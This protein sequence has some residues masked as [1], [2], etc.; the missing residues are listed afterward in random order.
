V[1]RTF[2]LEKLFTHELCAL[3]QEPR[4][5]KSTSDTSATYKEAMN[6]KDS[7]CN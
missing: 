5:Y 3:L 7:H 4:R 1:A 2:H 6:G